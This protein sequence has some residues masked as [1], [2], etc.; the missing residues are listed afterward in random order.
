LKSPLAFS[1][2]FSLLFLPVPAFVESWLGTKY[3]MNETEEN[4]EDN[5]FDQ[6]NLFDD[7]EAEDN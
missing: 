2:I 6:T 3:L 1:F 5:Q 7:N 4:F